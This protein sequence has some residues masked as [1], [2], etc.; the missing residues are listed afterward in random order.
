[1]TRSTLKFKALAILGLLAWHAP[2]GATAAVDSVIGQ[3]NDDSSFKHPPI[4][5]GSRTGLDRD[6]LRA[7]IDE[8][9]ALLDSLARESLNLGKAD[10]EEIVQSLRTDYH[11]DK[12]VG[13]GRKSLEQAETVL[14]LQNAIKSQQ[15]LIASLPPLGSEKEESKLLGQQSDLVAAVEALRETLNEVNKNATEEE[16]RDFGNWIM[17]SEGL[18]RTRREDR[19][20][21]AASLSP[22]AS[23]MAATPGAEVLNAEGISPTAAPAGL[24]PGADAKP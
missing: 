20:A 21:A 13:K 15:A 24:T 16:A 4:H 9:Q 3:K 8:G 1:M 12:F 17:V 22:A 10:R 23:A 6:A 7:K 5:D 18:L 19:E 2:L 11:L 14:A